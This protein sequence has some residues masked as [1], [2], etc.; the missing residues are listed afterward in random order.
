[1]ILSLFKRKKDQKTTKPAIVK[2]T[3]IDVSSINEMDE[4][5]S[6]LN[7][8]K[9][10]KSVIDQ[11][12]AL[13]KDAS[14]ETLSKTLNDPATCIEILLINNAQDQ[15]N[16]LKSLGLNW[17]EIAQQANQAKVRLF[18]AELVVAEDALQTLIKHSKGKDKSVYR[19][20]KDKLDSLKSEQENAKQHKLAQQQ[21]IDRLNTLSQS[22]DLTQFDA[23]ITAA[24]LSWKKLAE[25]KAQADYE[26]ALKGCVD[27]QAQIEAEKARLAEVEQQKKAAPV[28]VKQEKQPEQ[29]PENQEQANEIIAKTQ[30][31]LETAISDNQIQRPEL[32]EQLDALSD[33][34]PKSSKE[35]Y[36]QFNKLRRNITSI[37][38]DVENLAS[39]LNKEEEDLALQQAKWRWVGFLP[40]TVN[41]IEIISSLKK[42]KSDFD[43][44]QQEAKAHVDEC[45]GLIR[46]GRGA[47]K[48]GQVR[49]ATG[50]R[51]GI[52]DALA[53]FDINLH[54]TLAAKIEEYDEE[55][56]KLRDWLSYATTPKKEELIK[57][58]KTLVEKPL[59]PEDQAAKV[60]QLQ[61]E[62]KSLSKGG[63]N[64][65][66]ELWEEF[67]KLSQTAFEPCKVYFQQQAEVRAQNLTQRQTM[68]TSLQQY[69]EGYHWSS[70]VWK[71][72]VTLLMT[73][74]EEWRSY[75]P[76]ERNAN[77]PVQAKYEKVIG[78]I[79]AKVDEE[80][81]QNRSA[82]AAIV[83]KAK[84]L[85]SLENAKQATEEAK[86]LQKQWQKV[87][88]CNRKQEN[89]L[90]AQFR[91][92]CDEVFAKR[93][94][95]SQE[96][97]QQLNDHLETAQKIIN[98]LKQYVENFNGEEIKRLTAEFKQVGPLPKQQA[99]AVEQE[100]EAM[101]SQINQ[102]QKHQRIQVKEIR[103]QNL[104]DLAI[105]IHELEHEAMMGEN[106][107]DKAER[108]K[109]AST[110]LDLPGQTDVIFER[111]DNLGITES[112]PEIDSQALDLCIAMELT[113]DIASPEDD[114]SR[115]MEIQ[116][117]LLKRSFKQGAK[118]KHQQF[119][120]LRKQWFVLGP[121]ED[122][123]FKHLQERYEVCRSKIT[124][125]D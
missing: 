30:T 62:W 100:F 10:R 49:R 37:P 25:P 91:A 116:V 43:Q 57:K 51:H 83:E 56:A 64:E 44:K 20:T 23:K 48:D 47:I 79:Q 40:K 60:Q 29:E 36:Q 84:G 85:S 88:V 110:E 72:V 19:L 109:D 74:K 81:E 112:D 82:K 42:A 38:Q 39:W 12:A 61:Q 90:W 101:V 41:E 125:I 8:G 58:M 35:I 99:K 97:K 124:E 59:A 94:Q 14:Y 46:K 27:K 80:Y 75:S 95:Q 123:L 7:E 103:W 45:F 117:D 16:N 113:A 22:A 77:K 54:S 69:L 2:P 9:Q 71:D 78:A 87:G 66:Q 5:I 52:D 108:L 70:P 3:V 26:T 31:L 13:N 102:Q 73:A 6:L 104:K 50:I 89:E 111:L 33:Q 67:H 96:F 114:Q 122:S 21:I 63:Q 98:E 92:A 55:L 76:V 15:L 107:G 34:W 24:K 65:H 119:D 93:A 17:L 53:K 68:I 106:I 86:A 32:I 120:E 4:L 1:M 18:A 28:E 11:V 118:T 105:A 115:R 121:I